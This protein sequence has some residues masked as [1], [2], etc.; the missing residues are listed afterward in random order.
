KPMMK[1]SDVAAIN[2]QIN[3]ELDNARKRWDRLVK[4]GL[5]FTEAFKRYGFQGRF[6][7][8][9]KEGQERLAEI[10]RVARFLQSSTSTISGAISSSKVDT[11]G[12]NAKQALTKLKNVNKLMPR[13]V[14][15]IVDALRKAEGYDSS[16]APQYIEQAIGMINADLGDSEADLQQVEDDILQ[17][18]GL[19]PKGWE[20][21]KGIL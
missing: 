6:S 11:K 18:L 1:A 7:L 17:E 15:A 12:L 19:A 9:G 16:Q 20:P 13:V 14:D 21:V 3:R 8:K 5:Q 2:K 10:Q 4:N